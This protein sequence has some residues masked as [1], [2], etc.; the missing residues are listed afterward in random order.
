MSDGPHVSFAPLT[1]TAAGDLGA[2]G[3]CPDFGSAACLDCDL[4]G[5]IARDNCGFACAGK[6]ACRYALVCPC[7][8]DG[9]ERR[10]LACDQ[11]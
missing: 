1:A 2:P 5:R 9:W 6:T 10:R 4:G 3:V 11:T 8:Y 7:S